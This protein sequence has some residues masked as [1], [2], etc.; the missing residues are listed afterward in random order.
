MFPTLAQ[1]PSLLLLIFGFGFVIF[2]HE[3]GHFLAAKWVG[4]RVEQFAVGFGQAICS[5]RKGMGWKI[6]STGRMYE[7]RVQLRAGEIRNRRG[8]NTGD[9]SP[10]YTSSEMAEAAN[11]LG[12]GETEYRLNWIP[13]GGYVKML[14]QD[15]LN[16]NAQ[17]DDPRAYNKKSIAARMVVVSAGVIMNII[18]AA[19]GFMAVFLM[20]FNTQ[21]PTVGAVM[22]GSP[23]A[24]TTKLDGT[25]A[26]LVVGDR[27]LM[28]DDKWQH[29]FDKIQLNVALCGE[30]NVPLLVRHMDGTE[31]RLNVRP[32][33]SDGEASDFLLMGIAPIYQLR[34]LDPEKMEDTELPIVSPDF[35][36]VKP[37]EIVTA[38]NGKPV[39]VTDYSN[40]D[41]AKRKDIVADFRDLDTVVQQSNG[42]AVTITVKTPAG[43]TEDRVFHAQFAQPFNGSVHFAGM[44]PRA[45]IEQIQP[46]SSA[47]G[48][49]MPGDVVLKLT[50]QNGNDSVD[51]PTVA[52]VRERLAKAGETSQAVDFTVLRDGKQVEVKDL[53]PNVRLR[54]GVYGLNVAL[55]IDEGNPVVGEV[56]DK[57][58][59]AMAHIPA[60]S[61]IT[62]VDGK[63][64]KNW[65]DVR[66]A[67]AAAS[68]DHPVKVIART[69]AENKEEPFELK[70][71]K[72]D[73]AFAAGLHYTIPLTLR[74]HVEPR[75]TSSP[76][77]A[78]TWGVSETRDFIL[79]FYLTL[80]R[81]VQGRVSYKNMMGPVG[82]FN[83][84]RHFAF[85]GMDW[86]IWFLSMI[87]ANLAVVNFLPIPIVD[88]GLFTFLIVE[89]IQGRPLSAK[90]QSI[91]QFVGLA[92]ILSV[93]LLVTY[94]DIARI[95]F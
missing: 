51:D 54:K 26:P 30:G 20:G 56:T 60:R 92:I 2:F 91:A 15:D 16:P 63:P 57:S 64:V 76:V 48:K 67:F 70:L 33:T 35:L 71:D 17:Q 87:S 93:F 62:A 69:I 28:L 37:G 5:W 53:K 29:S 12:L 1:L 9:T 58:D 72:N 23:A 88:G 68:P 43:R 13:L 59:A 27:I 90:T 46:N 66:Q 36:A 39:R 10:S 8:N 34:G 73:I 55:S 74:E 80:H 31:E 19:I 40:L 42:E 52:K 85:K 95:F 18:L 61:T 11:E 49:L 44:Q 77:Q 21:P 38:I 50:L 75:K 22:P 83:A 78:A 41:D 47:K 65:F 4:I 6:G 86:L 79:Q 45:V 81:M 82:I 14:G 89:K 94:Q 3:L 7:E 25:P 84:G 24:L 32:A